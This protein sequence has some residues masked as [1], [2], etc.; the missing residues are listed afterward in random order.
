MSKVKEN[1]GRL[2]GY[3]A[4]MRCAVDKA[5]NGSDA[6]DGYFLEKLEKA[7]NCLGYGLTKQTIIYNTGYIWRIYPEFWV[8]N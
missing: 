5:K 6:E 8:I 2:S 4:S 1:R 3:L 7:A